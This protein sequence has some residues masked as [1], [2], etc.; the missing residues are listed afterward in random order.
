[1]EGETEFWILPELARICGF[2]F[3]AE[4]VVCVEFAQCGVLPLTR[5]ADCLGIAWHALVDGD[6]AGLRY[7]EQLIKSGR[8]QPLP[9]EISRLTRLRDRDIEHCF[10]RSGFDG[11][12]ASLASPS[13]PCGGS[14]T[15]V[16]RKAIEKSSKP[17]LALRLIDA[18]A[19]RGPESV[20]DGLRRVI[21]SSVKL[22]RSARR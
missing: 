22:A 9:D 17:Y 1:V 20:P 4:G 19:E 15:A 7:A 18:T 16:I 14:G 13:A 12:I 10:W 5:L 6:D 3:A 11:V 8:N 21:E 2:D